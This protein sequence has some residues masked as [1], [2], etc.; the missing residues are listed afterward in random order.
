[1]GK[2]FSR[3]S[4]CD[5]VLPIAGKSPTNRLK[6]NA[7]KTG[8]LGP[9]TVKSIVWRK[10]KFVTHP[11]VFLD[12]VVVVKDLARALGVKLYKVVAVLR[13]MQIFTSVDPKIPFHTAAKVARLFRVAAKRKPS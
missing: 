5:Y 8:T 9:F 4:P 3:P 2:E 13:E 6:L 7:K 11:T 12:N 1:M 10:T